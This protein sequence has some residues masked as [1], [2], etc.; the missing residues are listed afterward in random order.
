VVAVGPWHLKLQV[1]LLLQ[2][3]ADRLLCN[4]VYCLHMRLAF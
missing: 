1:Q 2:R 3:V 4:V